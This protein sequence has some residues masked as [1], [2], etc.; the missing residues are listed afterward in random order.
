MLGFG[1][2]WLHGCIQVYA[3][4]LAPQARGS[5]MALHSASFFLGQAAGPVVY[6]IG[7]AKIGMTPVLVVGAILVAGVGV[8]CS[9]PCD[10][11]RFPRRPNS[12]PVKPVYDVALPSSKRRGPHAGGNSRRLSIAPMTARAATGADAPP[13]RGPNLPRPVRRTLGAQGLR[14]GDRQ[15]RAHALHPRAVRA[16]ARP[17]RHRPDR[18]SCVPRRSRRPRRTRKIIVAKATGG[19]C[20]SAAELT[21][22]A[23]D[24]GDAPDSVRSTARFA[25]AVGRRR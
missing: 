23:D 17:A 12:P 6:G 21:L 9:R 22:G 24:R 4:E 2:Y 16:I 3:T 14:R 19:G 10:G 5:A 7:F 20:T 13:R 1:F 8:V 25:T 15:S 11:R 18:Q